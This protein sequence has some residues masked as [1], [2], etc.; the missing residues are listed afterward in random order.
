MMKKRNIGHMATAEAV[1]VTGGWYI[2]YVVLLIFESKEFCN[3]YIFSTPRD[4]GLISLGGYMIFW[5]I[6][7][8]I[9]SQLVLFFKS[10]ESEA[11]EKLRE[12]PDYGV[13]K[14]YPTLL[15]ILKL[16]PM[17]RFTLFLLTVKVTFGAMD[18]VTFLKLVDYGVPK[19]KIALLGENKFLYLKV[20]YSKGFTKKIIESIKKIQ[21]RTFLIFS[22]NVLKFMEFSALENIFYEFIYF[23]SDSTSSNSSPSLFCDLT[24]HHRTTSNVLLP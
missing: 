18:S 19:D 22:W 7:F 9:T 8:L 1:G 24:L 17:I 5:G 6:I 14:S 3:S 11:D 21:E 10:E 12:H 23:F 2:G 4:E 15:K 16:K 13:K 20:K